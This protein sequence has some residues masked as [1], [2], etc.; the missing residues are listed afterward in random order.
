VRFTLLDPQGAVIEQRYG[1]N[2]S[3]MVG[4]DDDFDATVATVRFRARINATGPIE[5]G[6]IGA[7]AW[8]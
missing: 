2:A 4:F 6:V 1:R 7:G 5:I 8:E 3:T